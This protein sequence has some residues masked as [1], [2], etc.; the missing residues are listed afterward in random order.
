V[1]VQSR[2]EGKEEEEKKK[3]G[4]G[5]LPFS[6]GEKAKKERRALVSRN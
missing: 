6:F 1:R 5:F 4:S 3:E 2:N